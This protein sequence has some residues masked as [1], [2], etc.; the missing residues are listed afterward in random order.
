MLSRIATSWR[1]VAIWLA[2]CSLADSSADRRSPVA[3]S[4]RTCAV[5]QSGREGRLHGRP[6]DRHLNLVGLLV[7]LDQHVSLDAVVVIDEYAAHLARD[8]A[9]R[10]S[11]GR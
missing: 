5:R 7:E 6:L 1:R 2:T 9:R 10:R 8:R 3:S 11:R 4:P